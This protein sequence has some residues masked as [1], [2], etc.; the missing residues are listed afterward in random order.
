MI[1]N[2]PLSVHN[3]RRLVDQRVANGL[4]SCLI[5]EI[6]ARIR[7]GIRIPCRH[8]DPLR[9]RLA[10]HGGNARRIF[11][12]HRNRI[13]MA[14]DPAFNHFILLGGVQARGTVP[15]QVDMKLFR[16]FFRARAATD[17]VR[18]A[19]RFRHYAD[20]DRAVPRL[21]SSVPG[22]ERLAGKSHR[23]LVRRLVHGREVK[24]QAGSSTLPT[25]CRWATEHP[26]HTLSAINH[27]VSELWCSCRRRDRYCL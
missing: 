18:V 25:T 21:S 15:N 10:E 16:R 3:A 24:G 27:Q 6:V 19:F 8:L 14:R 9:A 22:D 23:L 5:D 11:N 13:Y 7:F 4:G 26:G 1:A 12:A 17:E 20:S 2:S